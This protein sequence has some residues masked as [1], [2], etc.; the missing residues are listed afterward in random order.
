MK[1]ILTKGDNNFS[2]L[3]LDKLILINPNNIK[4]YGISIKNSN[5]KKLIIKTENKLD[6]LELYNCDIKEINTN[7]DF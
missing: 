4:N 3:N 1:I 7:H 5:I 2:N 6:S